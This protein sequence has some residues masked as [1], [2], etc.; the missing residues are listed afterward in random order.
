ME[1]ISFQASY[2]RISLYAQVSAASAAKKSRNA[3]LND[4]GSATDDDGA[5]SGDP[6]GSAGK[7]GKAGHTE[8]AGSNC[9][10]NR[11]GDTFTLSMEARSVQISGTLIVDD[12][13]KL[14]DGQDAKKFL[15]DMGMSKEAVAA[16]LAKTDGSDDIDRLSG[17]GFVNAFLDAMDKAS[18]GR[19]HQG[20][21]G[22]RPHFPRLGDPQDVA[23]ALLDQ[24]DRRHAEHGGSR[25]DF[26]ERVKQRMA[27]WKNPESQPSSTT[28]ISVEYHEFRAEVHTLMTSGVD[29]WAASG[30]PVDTGSGAQATAAA[31][32]T[33]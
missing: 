5:V 32:E 13:G 9:Q 4:S 27:N 33:A 8:K 10:R 12:A 29:A 24:L 1:K 22:H 17:A 11:D 30:T 16:V 18:S 26:A 23:N 25:S 28:R 3:E 2:T 31:P 20:Q 7:A 14:P 15:T 19:G 21:N 6:S